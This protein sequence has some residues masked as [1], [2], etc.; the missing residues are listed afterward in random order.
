MISDLGRSRTRPYGAPFESKFDSIESID[1]IESIE[2]RW[3]WSGCEEHCDEWRTD[4]CTCGV[5]AGAFF[6]LSIAIESMYSVVWA[7][8]AW[9]RSRVS[10]FVTFEFLSLFESLC[11]SCLFELFV[12]VELSHVETTSHSLRSH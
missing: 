5:D 7:S 1:P 3:R 9:A 6:L 2:V 10:L 12:R 11:S 8:P 4:L